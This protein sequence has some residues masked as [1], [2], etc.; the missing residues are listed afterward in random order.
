MMK[1]FI[2][3]IMSFDNSSKLLFKI[4]VLFSQ[5]SFTNEFISQQINAK[6]YLQCYGWKILLSIIVLHLTRSR[7]IM[8]A[9]D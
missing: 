9:R 8:I 5:K 1:C 3:E 4:P 7:N 2:P 6:F